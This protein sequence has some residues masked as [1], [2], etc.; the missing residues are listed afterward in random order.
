VT[1]QV[2]ASYEQAIQL[3]FSPEAMARAQKEQ[4]RYR[5]FCHRLGIE[6]EAGASRV[7]YLTWLVDS[8]DQTG[9]QINRLLTDLDVAARLEGRQRW[10]EADE[11]AAFLSGL[12]RKHGL[13][14][15]GERADPLYRELVNVL[16]D[17]LMAPSLPQLRDQAAVLL[18]HHTDL[19]QTDL[20]RLM[21][22]HVVLRRGTVTI[23]LPP[24]GPRDHRSQQTYN[25]T[26]AAERGQLCLVSILSRLREHGASPN[27][28]V[29][30]PTRTP[31]SASSH[32][33]GVSAAVKR[34]R[35]A[36]RDVA[37]LVDELGVSPL[38]IRDRA[39]LLLAYGAALGVQETAD[40]RQR[41]VKVV[42]E[43]LILNVP[44]R[45][46]RTAIPADPGTANDPVL[47]WESWECVLREQGRADPD[48]RAFLRIWNRTVS[49][50]PVLERGLNE[51][52]HRAVRAADLVPGNYA[53]SSLRWGLIRT[54]FRADEPLHVVAQHVGV[55]SLSRIARHHQREHIIR[56]S[57]A[58]QLGL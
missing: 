24:R 2:P 36:D 22:R 6:A 13:G 21:W 37:K 38:Q 41:D 51:V 49:G 55:K 40:L 58:G 28:Q 11:V 5:S 43:G 23:A 47:A 29:L 7:L 3:T 17:T 48:Q 46:G 35:T 53:Y 9:K 25:F 8:A 10:R 57:V 52:V 20:P 33:E 18:V 19:R 45:S 34:L 1:A 14:P 12:Y 56:R 39:I 50:R 54:A 31:G 42:P 32:T 27:D 15:T 26:V 4:N 16:I 30:P 44:G